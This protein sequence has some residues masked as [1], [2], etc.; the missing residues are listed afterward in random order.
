[1]GPLVVECGGR[2][3]DWRRGLGHIVRVNESARS[4]R[5]AAC[6]DGCACCKPCAQGYEARHG[7]LVGR[8]PSSFEATSHLSESLM[9]APIEREREHVAKL[10]TR[11]HRSLLI[12]KNN[13]FCLLQDVKI[14]DPD[15]PISNIEAH[16][17]CSSVF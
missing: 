13:E 2:V 4:V 9:L 11:F 16:Q 15:R 14:N 17:S 1:M 3:V 7:V 10:W 8:A 5:E 12:K 6:T